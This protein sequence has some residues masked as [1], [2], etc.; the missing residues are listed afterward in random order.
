MTQDEKP[1][2]SSSSA[3]TVSQPDAQPTETAKK[4]RGFGHS[5]LRFFLVCLY[6]GFLAAVV[7][8]ALAGVEYY[9]YLQIKKSSLGE[10]YKGRSLDSARLSSQKVAPQYGYEP[11]PGFA[12][13]RNTKLGNSFEYINDESFKDFKD[14]P[15]EKPANEYRVIVTGGSVIYG[16]GPVPP[17]DKIT[18]Y[19]E[20]TFRWTIPHILE[21]LMN[22]DPEIRKKIDGKEVRVINAGVPGYV[23]QNNLTRYLGKLRLYHPDLVISL[24]G[25]N[26]VHT[27]ARPLKDWNYFTEGPYW[28]V[29]SEV[30]DMGRKGLANYLYLWLKRNTYFFTWLAMRHGEGPGTLDENRG[31]ASHPQDP[32]PEMMEM[33]HRNI[34]QVADTEAIY[35]KVLETDHVPHVF[36]MQPMLK[37]CK[38]KLTPMEQQ[39][40]KLTGMEKIGFYYA[41]PTYEELVQQIRERCKEEGIDVIDLTGIFTPVTQWVWTDWCHLTNGANYIIARDL[42]FEVRKRV[43]DLPMPP[44]GPFNGPLD[45]YFI[46]Y[47][48]EA[49]VL[50]NGQPTDKGLHILKGYPSQQLLTVPADQQ[51]KD[52]GVTIDMGSVVPVSRLRIVWGDKESLPKHWKIEF[53]DDGQKWT[54]WVSESNVHVDGYDQWPGFEYYAPIDTPARYVR[55]VQTED[56]QAKEIKLRQIS[57]FR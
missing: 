8:A 21:K 24:D 12:A 25:A 7:L 39:I 3:P 40:F 14:V 36:A 2:E 9:A 52:P 50:V 19:Y 30:M 17:T 54:T 35:H 26:E 32:T 57:L 1:L 44:G 56:D 28:E 37:N 49:K 41:K 38:K 33:L 34:R 29:V 53:S 18:D 20:V 15:M 43:F 46:D 13:V 55:Y 51:S 6:I 47:A 10:A 42:F 27:V 23:I 45:S 22:A 4:S 11:T 16:R 48:K 5:V 31:F